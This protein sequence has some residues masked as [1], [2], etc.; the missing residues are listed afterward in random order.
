MRRFIVLC[1]TVCCLTLWFTPRA[2]A[3]AA[4]VQI[5]C[6]LPDIGPDIAG[7]LTCGTVRVPRDY[8]H[9]DAGSFGLAVVVVKSA[10]QPVR[11]DP[12]VY[13]S[14]GP[15]GPLT[16]YTAFQARH[17]YAPARDL[18]LIDQRATGRSEPALCP[19]LN[20][21]LLDA[22]LRI[23]FDDNAETE[24]GRHSAFMACRD[25][26]MANGFDLRNFGTRVTAEDFDR[27]RQ[28]LGVERW[29]VYGESYGTTVAMTLAALHPETL[30]SL[31]LDSLYPPDPVPLWSTIVARARNTFFAACASDPACNALY[32]DL[33]GT[34]QQTVAQLARSPLSMPAPPQL[35]QFGNPL[36]VSAPLFEL[37]VAHLLYYP[38]GYPTLL[39]I[40]Q[41]VHENS[42]KDLAPLASLYTAALE[43]NLATHAAVECR[44]RPHFRRP[45]TELATV[46]DRAQ[47]YGVCPD[48]S[49]LGPPP[50]VPEGGGV[51][52]LILAGQFDPV[53]GPALSGEVAGRIGRNAE[54]VDFAGIG[55]NVR[56]FSK[57]GSRIVAEFIA[58]PTRTL[59]AKCSS[60][61]A[62]IRFAPP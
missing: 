23:T 61:A 50:L 7:R 45:Y 25:M 54:I 42:S 15:G 36:Q 11:P 53:A 38:P 33:A 48:W 51:R 47:L 32:P 34:Y 3:E 4:F 59:D 49:E 16:I 8:A 17:P 28:A 30:R 37:V 12:V 2:V 40:I 52:T 56:H 13:I 55:H 18:I 58:D 9:P 44:D 21:A 24:A 35:A 10:V 60:E 62:P 57:C 29:N 6:D 31:V 19:S 43:Q 20:H 22:T 5:P 26:A 41:S 46:M 1:A 39:R 14:G 27:V